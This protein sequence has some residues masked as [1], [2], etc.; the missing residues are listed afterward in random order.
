MVEWLVKDEEALPSSIYLAATKV[1]SHDRNPL[2]RINNVRALK[3]I[4][5]PVTC[6]SYEPEVEGDFTQEEFFKEFVG[7]EG[8]FEV[9]SSKAGMEMVDK[10]LADVKKKRK[11]FDKFNKKLDKMEDMSE[12]LSDF[13]GLLYQQISVENLVRNDWM[14]HEKALKTPAA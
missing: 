8:K 10:T 9:D 1:P 13:K 11:Q 14:L 3:G 7:A 6:V 12:K 5:L 4:G 2:N